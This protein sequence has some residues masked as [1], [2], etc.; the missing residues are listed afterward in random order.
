VYRDHAVP[1]DIFS[2]MDP[3]PGLV[4]GLVDAPSAADRPQL[5]SWLLDEH[6]PRRLATDG[7]VRSAMVFR[8]N[9]PDS[10]MR[11]DVLAG[12]ARVAGNGGRL[13]I[14]WFL[15]ESPEVRWVGEFGGVEDD[16]ERGGRGE[17][18]FLAPFIPSIMGTDAYT[19]VIRPQGG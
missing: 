16:I 9:P 4:L 14:L 7:V 1:R 12:L 17:L 8:T 18:T 6:L 3:A 10:R 2:L 13:T 5:E 19:E 15:D 11:P